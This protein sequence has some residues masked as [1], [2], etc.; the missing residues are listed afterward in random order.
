MKYLKLIFSI[1]INF[2]EGRK[3]GGG[4]FGKR[5]ELVEKEKGKNIGYVNG[6]IGSRKPGSNIVE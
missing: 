3:D 6:K 1:L 2:Q 5:N 4:T